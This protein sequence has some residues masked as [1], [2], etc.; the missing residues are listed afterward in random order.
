MSAVDIAL[1]RIKLEEGFESQK[2]VDTEG[3]LTIGYGLNV[4]AGMSQFAAVSLLRA[5]VSEI[6]SA[7]NAYPWYSGLD[8]VRQSVCLDIAFNA[9]TAGLLR[10]PK[11]IAAIQ[12]KDWD[13]A[14][15]ECYVSNPELASRYA[16][17][18]EI[19]RTGDP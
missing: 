11:M 15:N 8:A 14:A 6:D 10:F 4:D 17:L 5:Q 13:T 16:R 2:Y 19:L 12:E 18:A 3:H 1:P 7:L 9:G